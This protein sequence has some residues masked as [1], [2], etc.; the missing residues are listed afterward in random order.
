[1]AK[2]DHYLLQ[3]LR[4]DKSNPEL[5]TTAMF[6][7]MASAAAIGGDEIS[8]ILRPMFEELRFPSE[9]ETQIPLLIRVDSENW[10]AGE[11][12]GMTISSRLGPIISAMGTIA[13]IEALQGAAGVISVDAS[14]PFEFPGELASSLPLVGATTVHANHQEKGDDAI[15]AVIDGG[16]DVLHEAFRDTNNRT[17]ILAVWDQRDSSHAPAAHPTGYGTLHLQTDIDGYITAGA[18]PPGLDPDIQGHGTHVASIAAGRAVGAFS[19]GMAPEASLIIVCAKQQR[20]EA[21]QVS[22]LAYS[23]NHVDALAWIKEMAIQ[24]DKAVAVNVS[25][26]MNAGAHDGSSLLEAAFDAF[27]SGGRAPGRVIVKSAGNE[28]GKNG[29]AQLNLVQNGNARVSWRSKNL[30]RD[31]DV[32]EVWYRSQHDLEFHIE[33]P[34]GEISGSVSVSVPIASGQFSNGDNF[35]LD[36]DRLHQDNGYSR[37]LIRI[38]RGGRPTTF[39]VGQW[40]L[41]IN[42]LRVIGDCRIDA[43]IERNGNKPRPLEFTNYQVNECC[44][45][46]PG[47]ANTVIAVGSLETHAPYFPA[48]SSSRGLTRD[49]REK[50]EVAAPGNGIQAAQGGTGNGS[51]VKAGT[52]MAAPHVTGALALLLSH[53]HKQQHRV[54]DW[55]QLNAV[56]M[57][58]ALINTC[59]GFNGSHDKASGFGRL[60]VEELINYFT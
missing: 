36:V 5:S 14:R 47:T 11:I 46:I 51:M 6:H 24:Y 9:R 31:Q 19:G 7:S 27:S 53:W 20:F 48:S 4:A 52:S 8:Y 55:R 42:A 44:L 26:G 28:G 41:N 39:E 49:A 13:T 25:Q 10:H 43:W 33:N 45:S 38:H 18:A 56:Q 57:R 16:I 50:P 1:M 58:A 59:R 54:A 3:S 32:I 40:I 29:H 2:I 17:R 35:D 34:R 15:I 22:S 21:G 60:D 37:L 23:H 12:P 30:V